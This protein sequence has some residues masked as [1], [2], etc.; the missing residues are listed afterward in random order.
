MKRYY[1]TDRRHA[2]GIDRLL[3]NIRRRLAEGAD[4]LQVREK[5]L[6]SRQLAALVERILALPNPYDTKILVNGRTDIA[7]AAG[8]DGV[9]LPGNSIAPSVFRPIVPDGFL[10][11]VSCHTAD[12]VA[13][14][15]N[16]GADFVVYGPV[17][18]PISKASYGAPRGLGDLA[19]VCRAARVPVYA[20]G[21]VTIENAPRCIEAGAAG[22]AGISIFQ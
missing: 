9:H 20:L 17:F 10:I 22:I 15:A 16:E 2:G 7:L 6:S 18:A 12:E 3:E 14:A 19:E 4:L 13:F 8:A 21:G 11:G 5:D 1:I